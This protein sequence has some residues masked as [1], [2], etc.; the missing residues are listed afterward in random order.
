MLEGRSTADRVTGNEFGLVIVA[1]TSPDPPGYS[2]FD[3]DGVATAVMV[4]LVTVADWP[5]PEDPA[6]SPTTQ[7]VTP[8]AAP[9]TMAI[10]ASVDTTLMATDRRLKLIRNLVPVVIFISPYELEYPQDD[11]PNARFA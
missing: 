2:W 4:R 9:P 8:Y 1:T 6:L 11:D 7:L 5:S 3:A 10:P